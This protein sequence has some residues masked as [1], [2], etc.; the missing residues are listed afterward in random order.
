MEVRIVNRGH[1]AER[2]RYLVVMCH[3]GSLEPRLKS[4]GVR[5][6][7]EATIRVF[8]GSLR[9]LLHPPSSDGA[10]A[11]RDFYIAHSNP[12]LDISVAEQTF[13]MLWETGASHEARSQGQ[14]NHYR[15]Q[16]R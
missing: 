10:R 1:V 12:L 6:V 3:K 11:V 5:P 7:F 16:R 9:R 15:A 8:Q 2:Y 14:Y 4:G 13:A